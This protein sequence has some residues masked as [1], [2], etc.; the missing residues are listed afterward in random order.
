M[1]ESMLTECIVCQSNKIEEAMRLHDH[2]VSGK[3]FVIG[4]CQNC[5]FRFIQNPPPESEAYKYYETDEY[6]EHSDSSQGL[7]NSVYHRAR[8][9]MLRYKHRIIDSYG[10]T[11]RILDFGTGT[12][13]F[14]NFMK[15]QG[16]DV[17]GIEISEKARAFGREKFGLNLYDPRKIF[18]NTFPSEFSYVTFWHVL[19]HVYEPSK[20]IQRLRDLLVDKGVLIVALPNYR[21]LEAKAYKE[22]WNG[23]DVPRHLWHWDK[24]S[25][26]QFAKNNGFKVTKTKLLPLDPYYNCLISEGYRKKNWAHILIPFIGTA[27][28][29][30]GWADKSK[31]SSIVYFLEKA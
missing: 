16:Y 8:Q 4:S 6:V 17:T 24:N 9:W 22:Y 29:L 5:G 10:K 12:G 2:L 25:F 28:L 3:L 19:E 15:S 23:Y 14:I 11:P 7:I 18:D 26:T 21:C 31:A 13:Y 1:A 20:V 27:S 30:H